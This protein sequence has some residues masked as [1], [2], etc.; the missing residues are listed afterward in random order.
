MSRSLVFLYAPLIA[1]LVLCVANLFG[2]GL[3]CMTQGCA[4]YAGY[5]FAGIPM[6]GWGAL[7][8]GAILALFVAAQSK[9]LNI[10]P[11]MRLILMSVLIADAGFLVWQVFFWPCTS[12]LVVA[13]LLALTALS[14]MALFPGLR[15]RGLFVALVIWTLAFVPAFTGAAKEAL[16]TPWVIGDVNAP[17]TVYLS[18]SCPSCEAEVREI[19]EHG[20]YGG[21]VAFIPVS[22]DSSEASRLSVVSKTGNI[23]DAFRPLDGS[24]R[25]LSLAMRWRLAK[26]KMAFARTGENMVPLVVIKGS[27]Q[28]TENV[29]NIVKAETNDPIFNIMDSNKDYGGAK[30]FG[31]EQKVQ[32]CSFAEQKQEDVPC[33]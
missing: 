31:V 3:F 33:H 15:C 1:G 6:Y 17:V 25:N 8:F 26:N 2:S 11:A 32:G 5:G 28:P 13:V 19:V 23:M 22:R 14:A 24:Q 4:V 7:T 9:A 16:I 20:R 12:C 29:E 18:P 27:L 30:F 21:Q 10:V